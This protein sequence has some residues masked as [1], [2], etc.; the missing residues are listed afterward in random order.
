VNA[1][2]KTFTAFSHG[3]PRLP[4]RSVAGQKESSTDRD[5]V[6]RTNG[7]A[8]ASALLAAFSLA[9]HL[10]CVHPNGATQVA[11]D[12]RRSLVASNRFVHTLVVCS[13]SQHL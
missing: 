3:E 13:H 4:E 12:M 5:A 2:C 10:F 7:R 11:P 1:V 9:L 8:I 6:L